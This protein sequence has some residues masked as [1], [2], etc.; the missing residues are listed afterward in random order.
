MILGIIGAKR[1]GK[2]T[3]ASRLVAN[4]EFTRVAYADALK[5]AAYDMNPYLGADGLRL[6]ELVDSIGWEAAKSNSEVRRLLQALGV[7]MR[8]NVSESV[9]TDVVGDALSAA[10]STGGRVVV[11]DVRFPNEVD[12]VR[13]VG[14][15]IVRI[16]RPRVDRDAADLHVSERAL[17]NTR[18]DFTVY[19]DSSLDYLFTQADQIVDKEAVSIS[20]RQCALALS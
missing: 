18:S 6:A 16:I 2:D 1:S 12:Q 9:W 19:N 4:H 7:A 10:A 5:G 15:A 8:D 13:A 17:D 11:T 14:G 20:A 3:F